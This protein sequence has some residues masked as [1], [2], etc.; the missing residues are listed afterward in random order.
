MAM[1]YMESLR[2][3]VKELMKLLRHSSASAGIH[4]VITQQMEKKQL[5]EQKE[6][7]IVCGSA[8]SKPFLPS[9]IN[10]NAPGFVCL[11]TNNFPR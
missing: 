9:V 10:A 7:S 6:K 3:T 4:W 1:A 2:N 5:K 11:D 8:I